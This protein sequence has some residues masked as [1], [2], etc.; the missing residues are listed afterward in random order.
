MHVGTSAGRSSAALPLLASLVL[1]LP[2]AAEANSPQTLRS[3]QETWDAAG[4][5]YERV[6]LP[7]KASFL[8]LLSSIL[9]QDDQQMP[10]SVGCR[11]ALVNLSHGLS[12]GD[13]D[14]VR[15]FDSFSKIK[16]G[17][18]RRK[19]VDFGNYDQCILIGGSR[20]V[21]LRIRWPTP[22]YQELPRFLSADGPAGNKSSWKQALKAQVPLL[23]LGT[24][25]ASVCF[26]GAC[27]HA[28]VQT[29]VSSRVVRSSVAP[30]DVTLLSSETL[31]DDQF[32]DYHLLRLFSQ[33]VLCSVIL[34][35]LLATFSSR[36]SVWHTAFPWLKHF[37]AR[38][39]REKLWQATADERMDV[40]NGFKVMYLLASM[41]SHYGLPG[42]QQVYPFLMEIQQFLASSSFFNRYTKIGFSVVSCNFVVG[43]ALASY[44]W[45][46]ELKQRPSSSVPFSVYFVIRFLRT[47]PLIVA[48]HLF[49]FA[50]PLFGNGLSP[51]MPATQRAIRD[52]CLDNWWRDYVFMSNAITV[53][54]NCNPATWFLA[55]DMQLYV[56]S[57]FTIGLLVRRPGVGVTLVL[58]KVAIGVVLQAAAILWS[59]VSPVVVSFSTSDSIRLQNVFTGIYYQW[60]NNLASY[61]VGLLL[62][63]LIASE[64]RMSTQQQKL[65]RIC[66]IM[67]FF[68]TNAIAIAAYDGD[69]FTFGRWP[70]VL[71]GACYKALVSGGFA[72]C[73]FIA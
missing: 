49:G 10:V 4:D 72:G 70:E 18:F 40:F 36:D 68:G 23:Y 39:H 8:H 20:Y 16:P 44:S 57:F 19:H 66:S 47:L 64:Y 60:Y 31:T 25:I 5:V 30:F 50:M 69:D 6:A 62:G 55:A 7:H 1:L 54:E 27:S 63:F 42:S 11:S 9:D 56:L 34:T 45:I 3:F 71:F 12:L 37:D 61:A 21:L 2:G 28:D 59:D 73:M 38:V 32:P 43:A 14:A 53:N 22:L 26:P 67:A 41:I 15:V 46:R 52:R 65:V 58:I 29:V 35:V 13:Y 48:C 33:S 17:T 51:Y 24:S